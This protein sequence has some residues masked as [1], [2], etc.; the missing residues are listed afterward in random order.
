MRVRISGSSSQYETVASLVI[1]L[2][3]LIGLAVLLLFAI[4]LTAALLRNRNVEAVPVMLFD[5]GTGVVD[6]AEFDPEVSFPGM[7]LESEEPTLQEALQ[8]ISD[9]IARNSTFFADPAQP[10]DDILLAGGTQGDGRTSGEGDGTPGKRHWEFVFPEGNTVA[11]YA[12]QLDFFGIELGVLQ[13]GGKVACVSQ[14]SSR[15][16][17][18]N[19]QP[20]EFEKRYYMTWLKGDL[21]N[22]EKE[23][24]DK[25]RVDHQE[26]LILKFLPAELEAKL[27][28]MEYAHAGE[29][30]DRIRATY[31]GVRRLTG[32]GGGYEFHVLDQIY[33]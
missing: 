7:E 15:S 31:F 21:Q 9:A 23:I 19:I 22:A 26:K 30:R 17:K 32:R 20:S 4:W 11:E 24:L 6:N 8:I 18:V 29:K 2:L 1:T 5:S 3:I 12:R 10:E 14:L 13:P 25:A 27:A 16:P 28:G 33:R